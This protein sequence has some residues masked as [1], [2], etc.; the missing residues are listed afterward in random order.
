MA[1][2]IAVVATCAAARHFRQQQH[3]LSQLLSAA[4]VAAAW[5]G[6]AAVAASR[7]YLGYHSTDQVLAGAAL[8]LVWGAALAVLLHALQPLYGAVARVRM[9]QQLGVKDTYGCAQPL[10]VE[11]A[12]HA[13]AAAAGDSRALSAKATNGKQL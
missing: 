3:T 6:A 13:E 10:L 12:A 7:V 11:A 4:E 5:V 1:C 2:C 9:L 8:G